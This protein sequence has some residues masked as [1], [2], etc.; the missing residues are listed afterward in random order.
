M[1]RS[2]EPDI[3]NIGESSQNAAHLN[4]RNSS[5]DH[6]DLHNSSDDKE[7]LYNSRNDTKYHHDSSDDRKYIHDSNWDNNQFPNINNS[8]ALPFD[9]TVI[10]VE[11][12]AS[13]EDDEICKVPNRLSYTLPHPLSLP[14]RPLIDNGFVNGEKHYN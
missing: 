13:I 5:D 10:K 14:Q 7:H 6:E 3:S 12:S 2:C 8:V 11:P 4:H 9:G 1:S